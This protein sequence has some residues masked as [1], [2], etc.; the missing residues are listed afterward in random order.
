MKSEKIKLRLDDALAEL[1]FFADAEQAGKALAAGEIEINGDR[2]FKPGTEV[3]VREISNQK[4]IFHKN[5]KLEIYI[6]KKCPYVSRGGYKLAKALDEFKINPEE[7]I[8]VDIGASTGGFTDC[9][10][11]RGAKKVFAVDCGAGLLHSKIRGDKRV[12]VMEKTNARYLTSDDFPVKPDIV[13]IDVSFISLKKIFPAVNYIGKNDTIIIALIKPQFEIGKGKE[14]TGGV[15]KN[16]KARREIVNDITNF[17]KTL[18]WEINGWVESPITGQAG[19]HE[20]L[21]AAKI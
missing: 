20:Y 13:V 1:A 4:F 17:A 2:N 12:V 19:N 6:R 16:E 11:Q 10:L 5:K 8:A 21:L 15:V 14:L 7:M 3:F 9:L 18:N